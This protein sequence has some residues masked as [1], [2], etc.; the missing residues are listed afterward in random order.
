[1][2]QKIHLKT[3]SS[4]SH[5]RHL[6]KVVEVLQVLEDGVRWWL[7]IVEVS[8]KM[9]AR[10]VEADW[11][12]R[13][14]KTDEKL[15]HQRPTLGRNCTR[16]VFHLFSTD[17]EAN[18]FSYGSLIMFLAKDTSEYEYAAFLVNWGVCNTKFLQWHVLMTR[19]QSSGSGAL[20]TQQLFIYT[21]YI[22]S[23]TPKVYR[24]D[25]C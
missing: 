4:W 14:K 6:S 11:Y 19:T 23:G 8:A 13:T 15:F 10:N 1:M 7:N 12:W 18:Y 3:A 16:Q 22:T 20:K 5:R 9:L 24:L 2:L 17:Q 21:C 25:G